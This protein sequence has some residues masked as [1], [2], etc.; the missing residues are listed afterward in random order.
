MC[1]Y[2]PS[3]AYADLY[4]NNIVAIRLREYFTETV[5][6][7]FTEESRSPD[8]LSSSEKAA[9]LYSIKLNDRDLQLWIRDRWFEFRV[10]KVLSSQPQEIPLAIIHE[11]KIE[12]ETTNTSPSHSIAIGLTSSSISLAEL[13]SSGDRFEAPTQSIAVPSDLLPIAPPVRMEE[14]TISSSKLFRRRTSMPRKY[15]ATPAP[16][17]LSTTTGGQ[18]DSPR[19]LGLSTTTGGQGDSP[20]PLIAQKKSR[21]LVPSEGVQEDRS[22]PSTTEEIQIVAQKKIR[23]QNISRDKLSNL[24]IENKLKVIRNIIFS[25]VSLIDESVVRIFV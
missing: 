18:G 23:A 3:Q 5:N 1:I 8:L 7:Y 10:F 6:G 16:L 22:N 17:S 13:V 24:T 12:V 15:F 19:P 11:D 21:P 4:E 25:R 14:P 2:I 9:F 20:R